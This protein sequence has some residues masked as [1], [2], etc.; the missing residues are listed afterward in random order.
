[1]FR[2]RGNPPFARR[3]LCDMAPLE[4]VILANRGSRGWRFYS[5][6]IQGPTW[7]K[8]MLQRLIAAGIEAGGEETVFFSSGRVARRNWRH[9]HGFRAAAR[10]SLW[11]DRLPPGASARFRWSRATRNTAAHGHIPQT[12]R[13]PSMSR[14][15]KLASPIPR[16]PA[17]WSALARARC[18]FRPRRDEP[19]S[20]SGV[21]HFQDDP[22]NAHLPREAPGLQRSPSA[23]D[24]A[25]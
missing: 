3:S 9:C 14:P 1:M 8:M 4:P 21:F 2:P 16:R 7:R 20:R 12:S 13:C 15:V 25:L 11:R 17:R 6:R 24:R 5:P 19:C 10:A 18:F 23:P 22:R